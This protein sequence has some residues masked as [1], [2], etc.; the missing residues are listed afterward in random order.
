MSGN[1]ARRLGTPGVSETLGQ[2]VLKRAQRPVSRV[3][4][5]RR[6]DW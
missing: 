4:G 3:D 2:H 5:G 6:C 1:E